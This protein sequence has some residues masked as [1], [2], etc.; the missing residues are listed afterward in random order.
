MYFIS[1][2]K[3]ILK[4]V[5]NFIQEYFMKHHAYIVLRM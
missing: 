4:F 5:L 2:E 3:R 1:N